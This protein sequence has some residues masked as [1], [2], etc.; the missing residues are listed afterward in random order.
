MTE[1]DTAGELVASV[2]VVDP[3]RQAFAAALSEVMSRLGD[4]PARD[5]AMRE[6][7]EAEQRVRERLMRRILN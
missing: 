6:I 4:C 7:V 1:Q 3:L 2:A 5:Y